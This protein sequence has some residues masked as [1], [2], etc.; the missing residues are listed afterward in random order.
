MCQLLNQTQGPSANMALRT[1][2]GRGEGSAG[3]FSSKPEYLRAQGE[4]LPQPE[5]PLGDFFYSNWRVE[6]QIFTQMRVIRFENFTNFT[7]RDWLKMK[8]WYLY[9]EWEGVPEVKKGVQRVAHPY[10]LWR[11]ESPTPPTPTY[12]HPIALSLQN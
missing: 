1:E 4:F 2:T 7:Q 9:T 11:K 10:W 5:C 12:C 8:K 6:Y 3:E